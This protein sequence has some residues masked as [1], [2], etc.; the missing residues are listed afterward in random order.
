LILSTKGRHSSRAMLDLTLHYGLGPISVK[1]IAQRQ[2][3]SERYL[4]N[5]MTTLISRGLVISIR[6]KGGGFM[7]SKPPHKIRLIEIIHVMEG[8][9]APVHC[10]DD[11]TICGRSEQCVTYDVWGMLKKAMTELLDSI[12]LEDMVKMYKKKTAEHEEIMYSI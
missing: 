3:I 8:S 6:G 10:V 1:E 7:L 4:E 9:I 2:E 11:P 5:I 12:T